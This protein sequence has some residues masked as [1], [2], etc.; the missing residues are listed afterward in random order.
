MIFEV[1]QAE[2]ALSG[3]SF[4]YTSIHQRLSF[5]QLFTVL[6]ASQAQ[7][8]FSMFILGA[9]IARKTGVYVVWGASSN[10]AP[11]NG[12]LIGC[13]KWNVPHHDA[14]V[15]NSYCLFESELI[16]IWVT[17]FQRVLRP[18]VLDN[19]QAS[20]ARE[21]GR[22]RTLTFWGTRSIRSQGT[23]WT[24][25]FNLNGHFLLAKYV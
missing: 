20:E 11:N 18:F 13:H 10:T 23:R 22:D 4:V 16:C 6:S 2:R 9:R 3:P 25:E 7:T 21:K 17:S 5:S 15:H 24:F 1:S 8:D 12:V 14:L 19:L